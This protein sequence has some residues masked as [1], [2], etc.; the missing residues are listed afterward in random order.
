[1]LNPGQILDGK[2]EMIRVLGR[3]GMKEEKKQGR[4]RKKPGKLKMIIGMGRSKIAVRQF[5]SVLFNLRYRYC[6]YM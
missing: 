3:G 6:K 1:M 4:L 2:Y 5:C